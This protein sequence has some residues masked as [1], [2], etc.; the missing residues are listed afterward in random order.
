MV[1]D[2]LSPSEALRTQAGSALAAVSALVFAYS[3]LIV[4]QILL[5]LIVVGALTIG[6]YLTYH[7]VTVLNSVADAAQRFAA[8]KEREVESGEAETNAATVDAEASTETVFT[9]GEDRD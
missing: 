6:A 2:P 9:G 3:L 7:A 8:A 5:G 1:H 4:G